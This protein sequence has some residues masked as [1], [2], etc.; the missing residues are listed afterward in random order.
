MNRLW[1]RLT[2]SHTALALMAISIVV[3]VTSAVLT[4]NLRRYAARQLA[5]RAGIIERI[6][7]LAAM[8]ERH[9]GMMGGMQA[10]MGPQVIVAGPDGRVVYDR[11]G[12]AGRMLTQLERQVAVRV[13]ANGQLAGY[14]LPVWTE[15]LSGEFATVLSVLQRTLLVT[16]L[17]AVVAAFVTGRW[18]SGGVSAP[19]RRLA[20]GAGEVAR[21]NLSQRIEP[22]GP[23]ETQQLA[24]AFNSMAADLLAAEQS[25]RAMT[26][27]IAHEL[28][29]P[30]A[31]LQ[32][33]LSAM[34]DGVYTPSRQELAA[35]YDE[36][37]RLS[38]LVQDLGQ[39]AELDAH[40]PRLAIAPTDVGRLLEQA[41]TLFQVAG[42]E[43]GV[44]LVRDWPAMLPPVSADASRLGQVLN[45]LLSNALR[46][47]PVGGRVDVGARP[48]D[49][50]VELWVADSG[51]GIS[52]EDL[53]HVFERFWRAEQSRSR[54][55]GG[56]GLGLSIAKQLVEAMGGS[57]GVESA[58]DGGTRFT[59]RLPLVGRIPGQVI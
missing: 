22:T 44:R 30:L 51:D 6:P 4:L 54:D 24:Q 28:R 55:H 52:P 32:G 13:Y 26:A 10:G 11:G 17:L 14:V 3:L 16:G 53:P 37:L 40:Q 12:G 15:S 20:A 2:L 9:Q 42:E 33:N 41:V 25:R 18:L 49:A 38:R 8:A 50:H 21:G 35:L 19:L 34:L 48:G 45:N 36:V 27:D 57:I 56:S 29:T 46:H 31:V 5:D 39:L 7:E 59:V 1:V 23:E 43:K 58:A 47:T